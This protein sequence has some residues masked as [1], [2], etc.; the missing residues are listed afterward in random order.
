[1][2]DEPKASPKTEKIKTW[3]ADSFLK[4]WNKSNQ[5]WNKALFN[6]FA[7][8]IMTSGQLKWHIF[9]KLTVKLKSQ[10]LCKNHV[11]MD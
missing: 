2:L 3:K 6:N 9:W 4:S 7:N 10:V 11:T 1:M 8:L 5:A